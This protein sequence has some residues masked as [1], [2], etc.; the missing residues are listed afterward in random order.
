MINKKINKIR[1]RVSIF[2]FYLFTFLF[3][4]VKSSPQFNRACFGKIKIFKNDP[5][6]KLD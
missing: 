6:S 3:F 1:L 5:H 2:I 4:S